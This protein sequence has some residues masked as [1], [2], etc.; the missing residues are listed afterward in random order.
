MTVRRIQNNR[1]HLALS[2]LSSI[3]P[4]CICLYLQCTRA[5]ISLQEVT[6]CPKELR[7]YSNTWLCPNEWG[8]RLAVL[9]AFPEYWSCKE[10]T[11]GHP[12]SSIPDNLSNQPFFFSN[13]VRT[14]SKKRSSHYYTS[15]LLISFTSVCM[16]HFAGLRQCVAIQPWMSWILLCSPDWPQTHSMPLA[17]T[18]GMHHHAC[19]CVPA[20]IWNRIS[21][22]LV[23]PRTH[24]VAELLILLPP[25]P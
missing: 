8:R 13:S 16:H 23:W 20:C 17:E 19:L 21:R 3:V 4:S 5:Y 22:S 24:C 14:R 15:A 2:W 6:L 18:I 25:P 10:R 12:D 9:Q 11:G 7:V 1:L